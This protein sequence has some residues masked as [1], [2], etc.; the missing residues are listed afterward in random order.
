M[1][2]HL[3]YDQLKREQSKEKGNDEQHAALR[4]ALGGL[5]GWYASTARILVLPQTSVDKVWM[6]RLSIVR[7]LIH[8]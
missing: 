2:L 7:I 1:A 5:K 8:G 3:L 6:N 4:A